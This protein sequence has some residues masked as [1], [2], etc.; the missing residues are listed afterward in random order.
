M[1]SLNDIEKSIA[2][3]PPERLAEFRAWFE[4]FEAEQWDKQLE[5]DI[6]AGKLD[7]LAKQALA[8]FEQG[9]CK[10]L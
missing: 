5:K 10:E 4:T 7:R 1:Q 2:N 3:L 6:Q 9:R 8:E